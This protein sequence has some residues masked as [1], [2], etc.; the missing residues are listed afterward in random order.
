MKKVLIS[1]RPL[2]Y[3]FKSGESPKLLVHAGTHGDEYEVIKFVTKSLRKYQKQLPSFLYVPQVS[4]SAVRRRTRT[5]SSGL[6]LNRQFFSKSRVKEV[7][8]NISILK[9]E[10]FDLF[11][12]FHEDPESDRYYIYDSSYAEKESKLVK[13]HNRMLQKNGV[14]LL[15]GLDNPSDPVLG[16]MFENGYKKFIRKSGTSDNGLITSWLL[17]RKIATN[18]FLPETPGSVSKE[19]KKYIID[20]FFSEVLIKYFS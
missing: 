6:D 7:L 9:N 19:N 5:N 12:S 13:A 18:C 20:T 16:N 11:V 4:P 14:K 2:F 3:Y 10:R 1:K 8:L 17:N 15:N